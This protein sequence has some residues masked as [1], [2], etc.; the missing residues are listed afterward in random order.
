MLLL[1]SIAFF[2]CVDIDKVLRKE[3]SQDCITP[4]NPHGLSGGY[5]IPNGEAVDIHAT[6]MK[7][8]T[9]AIKSDLESQ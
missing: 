7:A 4:S 8:K 5:G 3:V 9:L 1:Q 2:S 6:L